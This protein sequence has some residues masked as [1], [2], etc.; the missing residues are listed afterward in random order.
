MKIQFLLILM[1]AIIIVIVAFIIFKVDIWNNNNIAEPFDARLSGI[2]RETC[3][4][5]CT[6]MFGCNAFA[7][8]D[9]NRKCYLSKYPII[10]RPVFGLYVDEY[11]SKQQRCSKIYPIKEDIAIPTITDNQKR[12]NMLYSCAQSETDVYSLK[13]IKDSYTDFTIKGI[14]DI[15][16]EDYEMDFITWPINKKDFI[17]EDIINSNLEAMKKIY[18]FDKDKDEHLGQYL[19]PYKCVDNI[20]EKECL[21]TCVQ[22]ADCVGVEWNPIMLTKN[23]NNDIYDVRTNV[24]C[25]KKQVKEI[26]TRR[27][28]YKNG[29]FFEKKLVNKIDKNQNY[30]IR[31]NKTN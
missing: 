25:P 6:Q 14:D 27:D 16:Y 20:S 28:E 13:K 24:C 21:D 17:A 19:F 15:P 12:L 4:T 10:Q 2:S 29:S 30:Y 7:Y 18:V 22:N 23:K 3:G 26:I 31:V 11:D 9:K 5:I 8:D 1:V